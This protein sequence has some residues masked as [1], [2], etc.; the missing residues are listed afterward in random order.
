[1]AIPG[2]IVGVGK[3]V[4]PGGAQGPVGGLGPTAVSAD[5]GNIATLGSDSLILVPQQTLW[6]QRLRS[7]NAIG[8]PTFEVDQR[9]VGVPVGAIANGAFLQDRW[10]C[11]KTGTM[12]LT[13]AGAQVPVA[14]NEIL[15]PGTNFH[16]SRCYASLA[17]TTAQVS[18][19]ANDFLSII[20][21]IEGP[22]FREL[23]KDVHSLQILCRSSVSN[24][25]FGISLRDPTPTKSLTKLCQLGASGV[26]TLISLP[27]LPVFPAGGFTTAPGVEGLRLAITLACGSTFTSPA[28]DTWQS[29]NYIGAL[30]QDNFANQAVNSYFQVAFVQH[31]PGPLCT[32]LIDKPFSQ[33]L[34][35]CL[36][37]Y[38]KSYDYLVSAGTANTLV[39][40][41]AL[42]LTN[43][44]TAAVSSTR[45]VKPMAKSPTVSIY[46]PVTGTV[47]TIR[48]H[49][50]VEH[51]GATVFGL[52]SGGFSSIVFTT[53][54][55][56]GYISFHYTA[57]IGW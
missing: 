8:N 49:V 56:P 18:L 9:N 4:T 30:G 21:F 13:A 31:E 22:C 2:S 29:G 24:L 23:Y 57:D 6:Y 48:D 27:N 33:N 40:Q 1:M 25:K 42:P 7:Y 36:R 16:I 10:M 46:S 14:G 54:A 47:G 32:T 11:S 20:Q 44:S 12:V 43:S 37:Y 3:L 51:A 34:D 55:G 28:N 35:E 53:A 39:S 15:F 26:W 41:C 38:S 45:F 19:G 5:A 50:N 17:L 52:G